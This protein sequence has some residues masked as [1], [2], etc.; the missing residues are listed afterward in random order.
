MRNMLKMLIL[1]LIVSVALALA[2]YI[3]AFEKR[4]LGS[5]AQGKH[6]E[7]IQNS[8]HYSLEKNK[9]VLLSNRSFENAKF[10]FSR[11]FS[12]FFTSRRPKQLLP[13]SVVDVREFDR[14]HDLRFVWLGH[15]MII[16]ELEGKRFLIDPVFYHASPSPLLVKRYSPSPLAREDLPPIDAVVI[17]HDHYDHLEMSTIQFFKN[18]NTR[19]IMPLGVGAHLRAWDIPEDRITELDTWEHTQVG[20]IA[21]HLTPAQ[22]FSG[23]HLYDRNKTLWGSF[24][25]IGPRKRVFYSGDGG[26]NGHFKEIGERLGPFDMTFIENGA[27]DDAWP[28]VHMRPE[29][30]L[31]AHI[32][33]KGNILFPVH[34]AAY[35]LAFHEWSEP[36]ERISKAAKTNN[37][38]LVTPKMGE[39]YAPEEGKITD[40]WWL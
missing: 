20:D 4:A 38:N 26:Y 32:D 15:S 6:L 27:Y 39:L 18:K 2:L 7:R 11:I 16:L 1:V 14:V 28:H 37:V 21:I 9:F 24:S 17:S 13:R 8:R 22:H 3:F 35:D 30:S 25:F 5:Q 23:R 40:R 29:E 36:A 12:F 34:W 31:Q 19:F 10:P 33:V